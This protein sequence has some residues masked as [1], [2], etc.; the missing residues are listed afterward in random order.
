MDNLNENLNGM[1]KPAG[2]FRRFSKT[3]KVVV[4]AVLVLLL[5]IP[6]VMI[7]DMIRERGRTQVDAI[8][9]VSQKWS[10][11]QTITV[12][13]SICN[14]LWCRWIMENRR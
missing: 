11:A 3:I 10:L 14:I 4:I 1:E 5:L 13:I 7:E 6:M 8:E 9:E 12:L 2:C